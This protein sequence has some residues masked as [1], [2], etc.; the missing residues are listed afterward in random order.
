M[1]PPMAMPA[2]TRSQ[3]E[4]T[5]RQFVEQRG[6]DSD[7]HADHA[8]QIA[9]TR[10]GG[11]RQAA[12]R[13]HEEDAGDEI[14]NGCEIGAHVRSALLLVH[15]QHALG[16]EEAAEYV[17]ARKNERDK[18]EHLGPE[19]AIVAGRGCINAHRQER[20]DDND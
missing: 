15:G 9:L 7:A 4:K 20:T 14:K 8:E 10:G 19:R 11:R 6:R 1:P 13:Q 2:M 3:L 18:P 5:R 16:D 17:H 12:Q